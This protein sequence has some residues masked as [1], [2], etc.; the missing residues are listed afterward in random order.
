MQQVYLA[1]NGQQQGPFTI[2]QLRESAARG[3]TSRE[4]LAWYAGLAAWTPLGQ[5]LDSLS[6]VSA[7]PSAPAPQNPAA[8]A[9]IPASIIA[10]FTFTTDEL[11]TIARDQ[12]LLMWSVLAGIVSYFLVHIPLVGLLALLVA[13]V[14]EIVSLY[15]LGRS[16]R[17]RFVWIYCLGLFIPVIGLIILVVISGKASRV[18]KA[19]G[20]RVGLMGGKAADIKD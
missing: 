18:L 11:R 4:T 3:E 5:I 17:M 6:A 19:Y 7:A 1:I 14:F 20:V 8:P 10:E 16:L 13:V 15:K 12:N 9:A 2:D